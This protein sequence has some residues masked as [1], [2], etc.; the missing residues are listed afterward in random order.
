[1]IE[2]NRQ[3]KGYK[4]AINKFADM[5]S[6][7]MTRYMGLMRRPEGKVGTVPFPYDEEKLGDILND[8]PKEYDA[9]LLGLVSD[10]KS[11]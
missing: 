6:D 7:E 8:V 9:R 2:T 1:M 5:T 4:L 11:K 10:V 3:N